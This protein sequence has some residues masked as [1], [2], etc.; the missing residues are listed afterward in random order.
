MR[1]LDS[2]VLLE[3][4][5]SVRKELQKRSLSDAESV[6]VLVR[7]L[8]ATALAYAYEVLYQQIWGSQLA[9]LQFLNTQPAGAPEAR[10]QPYYTNAAQRFPKAFAMYPFN[11]YMEF[12]E[13]RQLI[14][15]T[16]TTLTITASGRQFLV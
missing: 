9:I 8:A 12:L 13:S 7:F 4:E 2:P 15:R 14:S 11:K 3:T 6:K 16:G 10:L 1:A 5:G